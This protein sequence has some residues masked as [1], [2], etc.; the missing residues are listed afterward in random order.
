MSELGFRTTGRRVKQRRGRGCIAVILALAIL[1]AGSA[2]AVVKGREWLEATFTTPDYSGPG[3]GSVQIQVESGQTSEDIAV[4][5]EKEGV[6]KSAEAFVSAAKRDDRSLMIQPGFYELRSKMEGTEA[7][8][9]LLDPAA[10]IEN[11]VTIPEG[12]RVSQTVDTLAEGTGIPA[13]DFEAV[14]EEPGGLGLPSYAKDRPE[15]FLFP[16]KYPIDPGTS[17]DLLLNTMVE[18]YDEEAEKLDLE[19]RA[20]RLGRTPLEV[21]TVASIIEAEVRRPNDF[22]K[23]AR[24][25]YNR[26]DDGWRLQMDSTV[27]YATNTSEAG[28][29]S[30]TD[31]ARDSRSPYNTYRYEGL[32]PGP[33]GS[34]GGAAMDA[35]LQPTPGDWM[36]FV[37]VNPD[38]GET[39]FAVTDAQ[40]AAN[41]DE[42]QDWCAKNEGRC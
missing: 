19:K 22:G 21:V 1:A 8:A 26:L 16:A 11:Y 18:R 15:G 20:K 30:T 6:V 42:W 13:R 29:V 36:Y 17:A 41:V 5:L 28:K 39:K 27:H 9:L 24:V 35:A 12:Q 34:P 4:T 25:I 31:E 14:L 32:P 33:I 2:I 7:L 38:S 23:V 3:S 37:A 10:R 40:H